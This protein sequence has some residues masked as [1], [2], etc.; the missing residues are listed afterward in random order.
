VLP[1]DP[2][3]S[4]HLHGPSAGLLKSFDFFVPVNHD[5]KTPY[6]SIFGFLPVADV[7]HFILFSLKNKFL[8]AIL[9]FAITVARR[10]G[11]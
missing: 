4:T 8:S 3:G 11:P 1:L 5:Q 9:K 6:L 10:Y 2:F 7:S